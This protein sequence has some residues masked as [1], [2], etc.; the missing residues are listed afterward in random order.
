MI[1][2]RYERGSI[3]LTSNRAPAEWP[4]LF[5]TP[6]LASAELERLRIQYAE[7]EARE[8]FS[9]ME[10]A[11]ALDQMKQAL[12]DEAP[13]ERV[14]EALH[15]NRPRRQQLTRLLAFTTEQQ[16][17]VALLRLQETQVGPLHSALRS[18]ELEPTQMH[19]VLG[20]LETIAAARAAQRMQSSENGDD[21]GGSPRRT[22]IDDPTVARLVAQI[23]REAAAETRRSPRWFKPLQ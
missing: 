18:G 20:R 9:A 3:L 13:W 16:Q 12:G 6:L 14:E 11:W 1:S 5:G 17:R 21:A 8:E 22:G 7:N 4:E 23:K 15:L 10:R 2:Q 19:R